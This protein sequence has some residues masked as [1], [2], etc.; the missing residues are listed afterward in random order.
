M[1]KET[2]KLTELANKHLRTPFK[3][4]RYLLEG[5]KAMFDLKDDTKL[6]EKDF[7]EK[8]KQFKEKKLED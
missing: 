8:V 7:L 5:I 4:E 3:D 6:T 1:A 2:Y